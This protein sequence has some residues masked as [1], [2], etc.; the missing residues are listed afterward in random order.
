MRLPARRR[1]RL[2]RHPGPARV[3]GCSSE[4]CADFCDAWLLVAAG[5]FSTLPAS[6]A[7]AS[8]CKLA[9]FADRLFHRLRLSRP[10]QE[11]GDLPS[12]LPGSAASMLGHHLFSTARP[13]RPLSSGSGVSSATSST[14]SG[15]RLRVGRDGFGRLLTLSAAWLSTR[16]VVS[17]GTLPALSPSAQG[18]ISTADCAPASRPAR[19]LAS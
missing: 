3:H 6:P 2:C 18:S 10:R 4:F 14:G 1:H 17:C 5:F 7:P 12:P 9:F 8:F 16:S 19:W 15:H 13:R 11:F